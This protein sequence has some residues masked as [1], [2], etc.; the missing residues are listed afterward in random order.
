MNDIR[1]HTQLNSTTIE[2]PEVQ[3]LIGKRVEIIVREE[4]NSAKPPPE[5]VPGTGDWNA[6]M[7]AAKKLRESGYDFDAAHR[8]RELDRK[9]AADHL[10]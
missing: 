5:V 1:I 6:A 8:Q 2:I 7:Q 9:Q 10:P 4:S 3:P